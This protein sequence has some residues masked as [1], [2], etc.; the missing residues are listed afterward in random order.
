MIRNMGSNK[1]VLDDADI[2]KWHLKSHRGSEYKVNIVS[3]KATRE[4]EADKHSTDPLK[5]SKYDTH[6]SKIIETN[7]IQL[8]RGE[9]YWQNMTVELKQGDWAVVQCYVFVPGCKWTVEAIKKIESV[10]IVLKFNGV[11]VGYDINVLQKK[12][13]A[14]YE[15]FRPGLCGKKLKDGKYEWY[16]TIKW[17]NEDQVDKNFDR[18]EK[19]K[20]KLTLGLVSDHLNTPPADW[21]YFDQFPTTLADLKRELAAQAAEFAKNAVGSYGHTFA[22]RQKQKKSLQPAD[23]FILAEN[24]K[25]GAW[26]QRLMKR[27]ADVSSLKDGDR[28]R[29]RWADEKP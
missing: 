5:L 20:N 14:F 25:T 2:G 18:D 3:S 9:D 17:I 1:V 15:G 24:E 28:I 4:R 21:F 23:I 6:R 10:R 8:S 26:S 13:A 11:Y 12:A 22:W 19:N 29:I 16:W 7:G 27:D